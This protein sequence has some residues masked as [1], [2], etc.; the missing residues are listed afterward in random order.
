M[1]EE[2]KQ[3]LLEVS[4]IVDSDTIYKN[5]KD[6]SESKRIISPCDTQETSIIDINDLKCQGT[7]IPIKEKQ[8]K[9][10][11]EIGKINDITG[12]TSV[13]NSILDSPNALISDTCA[14]ELRD[15]LSKVV[16]KITSDIS[17]INDVGTKIQTLLP[18]FI[19]LQWLYVY[20]DNILKKYNNN[21]RLN[22]ST[23]SEL[24]GK[25]IINGD[26]TE[27]VEITNPNK[28]LGNINEIIS[29]SFVGIMEIGDIGI[30]DDTLLANFFNE[31]S[32]KGFV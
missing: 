19:A 30:G 4:N 10:R 5:V 2:L 16:N 15:G 13:D 32:Y 12:S 6:I 9:L 31:I 23:D 1:L 22:L 27:E 3:K 26:Y 25:F 14:Q 7:I 11:I 28:D 18:R 8:E 24:L 21:S 17:I 29:Y 20:N